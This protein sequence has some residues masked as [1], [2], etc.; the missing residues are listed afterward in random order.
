MYKIRPRKESSA[1]SRKLPI[2]SKKVASTAVHAMP[3]LS[4]KTADLH[5]KPQR[6]KDWREHPLRFSGGT[7]AERNC[8]ESSKFK[9]LNRR[10][11]R[12]VRKAPRN[13]KQKKLFSCLTVFHRHFFI[14]LHQQFQTQFQAQFQ[15][16]FHNENL[17]WQ[18]R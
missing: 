6:T 10:V 16:L 13:V 5:R 17:Q 12:K 18:P 4:Q 14:V 8:P 2:V 3:R 1:V 11:K 9:K 7:S 15:T